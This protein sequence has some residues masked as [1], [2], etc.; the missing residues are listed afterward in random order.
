MFYTWIRV[1][2]LLVLVWARGCVRGM[3]E[4][5]DKNIERSVHDLNLGMQ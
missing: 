3:W 2:G 5:V 4:S 1:M